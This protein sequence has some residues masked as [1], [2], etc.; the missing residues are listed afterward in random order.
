MPYTAIHLDSIVAR[1]HVV[2]AEQSPW[3]NLDHPGV[4]EIPTAAILAQDQLAAPGATTIFANSG[5]DAGGGETIAVDTNDTAIEHLDDVAGRAPIVDPRQEAPGTGPILTFVDVG[6]HNARCVS[7]KA[8]GS[9]DA[10]IA[11]C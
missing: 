10:A 11:Q 5:P 2:D 7:L 4:A 6:P 9:E 8:K 3:F 1:I